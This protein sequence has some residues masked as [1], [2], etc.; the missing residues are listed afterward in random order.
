[1][2][3]ANSPQENE[4]I[5]E[6]IAPTVGLSPAQF[7]RWASLLLGPVLRGTEVTLK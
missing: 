7:P 5:D 1:M 4:L 2:G 6:L 3:T